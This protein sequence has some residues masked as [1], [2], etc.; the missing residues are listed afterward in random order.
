MLEEF[1]GRIVHTLEKY[2]YLVAEAGV[3]ILGYAYVGTFHDRPAYDWA[4]ETSI[5]IDRT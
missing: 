5:Y 2:P 3:E 4:V 1:S